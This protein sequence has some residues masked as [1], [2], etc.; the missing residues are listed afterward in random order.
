[1]NVLGKGWR[2]ITLFQRPGFKITLD[3]WMIVV[4]I[5]V[6]WVLAERYFPVVIQGLDPIEYAIIGFAAALLL[7]FSVFFHEFGHAWVAQ[8]LGL[9]AE[10]IHLFLL[11]GLAELKNRPMNPR[12]E[13]AIALAGPLFSMILALLAYALHHQQAYQGPIFYELVDYLFWMNLLLAGFNAV[14]I[15]PLDGGRAM[16][17]V[18]W[19][20]GGQYHRASMATYRVS[21]DLIAVLFV[22]GFVSWFWFEA[23]FAFWMGLFA[24]YMGVTGWI[25]KKDLM[26][27]PALEDMIFKLS[28]DADPEQWAD[29]LRT[30]DPVLLERGLL[31]VLEQ[32]ALKGMLSGAQLLEPSP[33]PTELAAIEVQPGSYIDLHRADS[34]HANLAFTASYVPVFKNGFFLGLCDPHELRFWLHQRDVRLT[35]VPTSLQPTYPG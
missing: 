20:Y 32:G 25:A 13:S 7:L 35:K 34:Y 9:P 3:P 6:S 14:P 10:R 18:F 2:N 28:P 11:G 31:P 15:Y 16:R 26:H 23:W 12:Q 29:Q 22:L 27:R 5:A 17:G 19:A 1:M 21:M 30:S 33:E 8:R 4:L 24:V